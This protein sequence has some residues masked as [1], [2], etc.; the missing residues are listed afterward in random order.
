MDYPRGSERISRLCKTINTK[1]RQKMDKKLP[2][3]S[4]LTSWFGLVI[5]RENITLNIPGIQNQ[6]GKMEKDGN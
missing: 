3:L 4:N 5:T 6:R 1:I 2:N